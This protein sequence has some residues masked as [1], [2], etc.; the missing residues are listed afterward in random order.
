MKIECKCGHLIVDS[1]DNLTYKGHII[2]DQNLDVIRD[3]IDSAIESGGESAKEK[4]ASCM[5]VRNNFTTRFIWQCTSC[6]RI[7]IDNANRDLV[8]FMPE[9]DKSSDILKA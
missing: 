9:S 8:C 1:T 3:L 5:N 6:N 4:E 2:A 7:Y